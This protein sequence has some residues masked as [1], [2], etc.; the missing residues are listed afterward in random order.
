M[1]RKQV[2][3]EAAGPL[4]VSKVDVCVAYKTVFG[5][6]EGQIVLADLMRR[7]SF[8]RTSTFVPGDTYS[9]V[10]NE[11]CRTVL[12]HIG[13]MLDADPAEMQEHTTER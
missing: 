11:G 2:A 3:A 4:S 12:I 5:S 1:P 9:T 7:F 10:H 6:V 13:R 8:T